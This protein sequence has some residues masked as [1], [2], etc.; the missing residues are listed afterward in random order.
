MPATLPWRTREAHSR[1]VKRIQSRPAR[2][3]CVQR[4]VPFCFKEWAGVRKHTTGRV[5][6]G[7]T[8]DQ[9]SAH[10]SVA[11]P[12]LAQRRELMTRP[13]LQSL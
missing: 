4:G 5:L 13:F 1:T 2:D 10:R 3:H 8:W 11:I 9:F 6:D 12:L 7:V